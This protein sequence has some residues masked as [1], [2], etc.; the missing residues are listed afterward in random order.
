M[1]KNRCIA[2]LSIFLVLFLLLP[3]SGLKAEVRE[4]PKE[5]L[6]AV[7]ASRET[8]W[9]AITSGMGSGATVAIMDQ[10]EIVYSERMG[11]ADRSTN[12]SV[13]ANTR[14]NIGSTSKMFVAVAILLL[15]D[16]GRVAL[17]EPVKTYLPEFTMQDGRYR[18]ITVR[19]LF[20]HSSGLPGSSFYFG[21]EPDGYMHSILLETLRVSRLK[22]A[23]DAMSIYCNDGFTLAEMI[24]ERI[25]DRPYLDF[26]KERIFTPLGMQNTGASVGESDVTNVADYYLTATGVRYPREAVSV[27]GAGGLSSTAEDLCRFGDSLAPHGTSRILSDSSLEVLL[28]TQP[29][30]FSDK[31]R[32]R[33]MMSEF[34]WEYTNLSGYLEQ[35]IQ[36]LGKGGNT[37]FYSTNL[38]LIPSK[39][40]VIALSIS[41]RASGEALTRPILDALMKDKGLM[42]VIPD[43]AARRPVKAEPIPAGILGYEGYYTNG[44]S[45]VQVSADR[46]NQL[47]LIIPQPNGGS[48]PEPSGPA[49]SFTYN[50]GSFFNFDRNIEVYFTTVR[51]TDYIVMRGK[52][53]YEFDMLMYQKLKPVE[54]PGQLKMDLHEKIWLVRNAPWYIIP[55]D[56]SLAERSLIHEEL[57][58]YVDFLGIKRVEEDYFARTAA[59]A[60]RD[61][62][63]ITLNSQDG[64]M[65]LRYANFLFSPADDFKVVCKGISTPAGESGTAVQIGRDGYNE[66]LRVEEDLV[67][68]FEIPQGGRVIVASPGDVLLDSVV[69]SGSVYV[70]AGNFV[71]FAGAPGDRF[72][73]FV[74]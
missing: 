13:D 61:Q 55:D 66:W 34:G 37:D 48:F 10:G 15:V 9:K 7:T 58:G 49:L 46:D 5:Y 2:L 53:P 21:Y 59:K 31:L 65:W 57:P 67:L 38:Q 24:V 8:I 51:D 17:D 19:M 36:V 63:D 54:Q 52:F 29:T 20:N 35:G 32:G 40:L 6:N 70:P 41:G 30:S 42:E 3:G 25:S 69:D 72:L 43:E 27:Y 68:R 60:F 56:V 64:T 71:F 26:L 44:D 39:R 1:L 50:G 33:Q 16:E 14:F 11:V 12:R 74:E 23:P 62:S 18:D 45:L 28:T 4:A 73:V 47:L 22:H